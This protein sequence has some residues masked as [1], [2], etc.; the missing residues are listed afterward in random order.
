MNCGDGAAKKKKKKE[1]GWTCDGFE[2]VLLEVT[3]R[4]TA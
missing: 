3:D 2:A 1:E 4:R